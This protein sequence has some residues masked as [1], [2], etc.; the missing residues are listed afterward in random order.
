MV[1][2]SRKFH[3]HAD[4]QDDAMAPDLAAVVTFL[5][6]LTPTRMALTNRASAQAD[7]LPN[8]TA[9]APAQA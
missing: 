6:S 7:P 8:E 9:S 2:E 3:A 1:N 5:V 4:R